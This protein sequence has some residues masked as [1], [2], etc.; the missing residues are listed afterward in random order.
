MSAPSASAVPSAPASLWSST[1]AIHPPPFFNKFAFRKDGMDYIYLG[2]TGAVVSRLALGLMSY[3]KESSGDA[4]WQQWVL[5]AQEGEAFIRQALDA[6]VTFFDTAEIYSEGRSEQF[7]GDSLQ[8]LL[9]SSR[10]TRA[11]LFISTKIFPTR[12]M[13]PASAFAGIQ[14]S[15]SRKAI[16]DAVEGSLRRLQLDYIDLYFIHRF[17]PNTSPDETMKALHDLVVAGKIRYLGAS[18]MWTWQV[19]RQ[20]NG[21]GRCGDDGSEWMG[22]HR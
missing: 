18:S 2:S 21:W 3:A 6:G 4:K 15:L 22:A 9:P 7:F 11:D 1:T 13:N 17:D 12:T 20:S 14:K 8:K 16:F 19:S 10:F 5:P